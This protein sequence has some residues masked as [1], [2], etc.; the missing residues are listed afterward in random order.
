VL[1]RIIPGRFLLLLANLSYIKFN[2]EGRYPEEKME[3]Y[4]T[5][6]VKY[7]TDWLGKINKFYLWLSRQ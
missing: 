3:F 1:F 7:A 5:A 2:I 4:Q 6:T